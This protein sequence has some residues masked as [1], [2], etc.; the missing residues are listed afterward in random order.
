MK[1]NSYLIWYVIISINKIIFELIRYF[2]IIFYFSNN[3]TKTYINGVLD[4][5]LYILSLPMFYFIYIF[6]YSL[7][8]LLDFYCN[9]HVCLKICFFSYHHVV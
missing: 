9:N 5:G 8:Y 7:K 2:I 3:I 6:K 4:F 1:L